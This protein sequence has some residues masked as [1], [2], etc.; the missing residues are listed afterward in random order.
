MIYY[1]AGPMTGW[2]YHNVPAFLEAAKTLRSQGLECV[3]PIEL[4]GSEYEKH[5]LN[6]PTGLAP[7]EDQRTWGDFL[8]RDVKAIADELDAVVLL[9]GWHTSKGARLET[10]V[11]MNLGYPIFFYGADG[12][13]HQANY[14]NL[15]EGISNAILL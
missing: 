10:F 3:V 4:D 14:E 13:L 8:S 6:D 9:P 2:P 15:M 1:I 7:C 12:V 11:A 5:C